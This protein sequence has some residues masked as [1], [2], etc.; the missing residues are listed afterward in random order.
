MQRVTFFDQDEAESTETKES[1]VR[2]PD[3]IEWD[4]E[5]FVTVR[6]PIFRILR[7]VITLGVAVILSVVGYRGARSWFE[8]QLDPGVPQGNE[9]VISV[10]S[11]STTA[12]I[13]RIL[14]DNEVIPNHTFFRYY[15]DYKDTGEFQAGEY[16]FRQSSSAD[17]AIEVLQGGPK[18]LVFER[19]TVREGLWLAEILDSLD[20]QFPD[21]SRAEFSNVLSSR[22]LQPRYR[23]SDQASWEGLL[24]PDTYEVNGDATAAEVIEKMSNQFSQVT[25][26]LAYGAAENQ[27]GLSAYEVLIVASLIEAEARIPEE[28]PLVAAVIYN[29][30]RE[31]IPLGIDATCIYMTGDRHVELTKEILNSDDPFGCRVV[32][33]LPPHPINSPGR[34]S[35]E[36]AIKPAEEDYLYYVLTDPNGT[37]TFATTDEEFQEAKQVCQDLG[38]CG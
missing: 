32:V 37:H 6:S 21:I 38:L 28:R 29:R 17:Q 31:R 2:V 4:D 34:A 10:P 16:T 11:G 1:G 14:E 30:L 36:A 19:F 26:A 24:F 5:N 27:L 23:P 15:T 7:S 33:G 20:S 12:D 13:A 9:I 3:P 25:G 35:L 8:H 18:P 22:Q